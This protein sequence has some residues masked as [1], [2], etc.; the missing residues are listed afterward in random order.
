[1]SKASNLLNGERRKREA[2]H[3]CAKIRMGNTIYRSCAPK[4]GNIKL[5]CTS[6]L[7]QLALCYCHEDN[8]NA[9]VGV[10]GVGVA[11]TLAGALLTLAGSFLGRAA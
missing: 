11:A 6:S 2:T 5:N 3:A 7:G 8:C 4:I 1:M 10:G 9:A